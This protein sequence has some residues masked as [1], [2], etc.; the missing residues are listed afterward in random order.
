MGRLVLFIHPF[1]S[2]GSVLLLLS[3]DGN[4]F[5]RSALCG[6]VWSGPK[7]LDRSIESISPHPNPILLSHPHHNPHDNN[8]KQPQLVK[9]GFV[10]KK[11]Q[12]VHSRARFLTRLEAK[13]KGRHTGAWCCLC[14]WPFF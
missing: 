1:L 5:G 4:V 6:P 11:P 9:D 3:S 13:R 7:P 2:W 10:L 14:V 8:T 12:V